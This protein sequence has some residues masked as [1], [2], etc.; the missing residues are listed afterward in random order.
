MNM[1]AFAFQIDLCPFLWQHG[2]GS[3]SIFFENTAHF[4]GNFG[5]GS[6]AV[7]F[8]E[9]GTDRTFL[10]ISSV[11]SLRVNREVFLGT[12]NDISLLSIQIYILSRHPYFRFW[13][14]HNGT[15][16]PISGGF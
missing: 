10:V 11:F 2:L 16:F 6:K 4:G 15:R 3:Y 14:W 8:L 7:H 12:D 9:R 1:F 13:V 5:G